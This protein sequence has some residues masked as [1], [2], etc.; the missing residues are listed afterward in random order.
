MKT[1]APERPVD[2]A[3]AVSSGPALKQWRKQHGISRVQFSKMADISERKMAT[4]EKA[5]RI[6]A[7]AKRPVNETVRLIRAI[8]ELV[9]NDRALKEWLETPNPG[10]DQKTPLELIDHGESDVLWEMVYQVRQGAF[11]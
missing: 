6:P 9:G 1:L 2:Q 11:A 5:P 10:F 4:I 7:K 8:Q 3:A